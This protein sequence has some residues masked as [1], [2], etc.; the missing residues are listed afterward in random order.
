MNFYTKKFFLLLTSSLL[1]STPVLA[2]EFDA[3]DLEDEV[4]TLGIS[5]QWLVAVKSW[6]HISLG[7]KE[8]QIVEILRNKTNERVCKFEDK[9]T[10]EKGKEVLAIS[11]PDQNLVK[12]NK[13]FWN[14]P[15]TSIV[16][17]ETLLL[18]QYLEL[19][20]E[21]KDLDKK[22]EISGIYKSGRQK[23]YDYRNEFGRRLNLI[24]GKNLSPE[25]SYCGMHFE[26]EYMPLNKDQYELDPS[27][28]Y[29]IATAK[30]RSNKNLPAGSGCDQM[31][32]IYQFGCSINAENEDSKYNYV[33]SLEYED[34]QHQE[35]KI[36][37]DGNLI[38]D[39]Y[40]L[41]NEKRVNR[42]PV[43]YFQD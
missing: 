29:A 27:R 43:K 18:H 24:N 26:V 14:A 30:L 2:G 6:Y 9:L 40:Y 4:H 28:Q 15:T 35:I 3:P 34:G 10:G 33:C 37:P 36:L 11:Y 39:F 12:I 38:Q 7:E 19:N 21:P 20:V 32:R 23:I 16:D 31:G 8:S 17:K 42:N 22:Y 13:A 5:M 1:I 25:E 41:E